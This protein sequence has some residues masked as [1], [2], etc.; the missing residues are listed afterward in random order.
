[1]RIPADLHETIGKKE[2]RY[3]LKT[4]SIGEAKTRARYVAGQV[5]ALFRRLKLRGNDMGELGRKQISQ[6]IREFVYNALE[7]E[8]AY[9]IDRKRPMNDDELEQ[10]IES[11]GYILSDL[12][13]ELATGRHK[14]ARRDVDKI[15]E[16]KGLRIDKDSFSYNKLC[17]EVLKAQVQIIE[18][19]IR[20]RR[21]R[22]PAI[23]FDQREWDDYKPPEAVSLKEVIKAFWDENIQAD[24]WAD[25]TKTEY[26]TCLKTMIRILGDVPIDSITHQTMREFKE[27]LMKLPAYVSN[28]P[29]YDGKSIREILEM[30]ADQKLSISS[31]NKYLGIAKALF[32]F[33]VRNNYITSNP[34]EGLQIS[35]KKRKRG[36]SERRAVFT[37]EDLTLLL[38]SQEYLKDKHKHPHNFWLPLL[39]LFTGARIEELCQ[40][41]VE[42]VKELNG[43][44]VLDI[45]ANAQ[46][47]RLKTPDSKRM[48]PLH[49]FLVE[50]LRFIKFV[51]HQGSQGHERI[52]PELRRINYRYS[53][54]PSKWFGSYRKRCGISD[55]D[56][57]FHSFRHGFINYLK[58]EEVNL[59]I[60]K[61]LVGH[62]D[63]DIT[64]GVYGKSFP[65][66]KLYHEAISKM[67]F[68]VDLSHLKASR[69]CRRE[70]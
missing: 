59:G 69:F 10:D 15:I 22:Y 12:R 36:A 49:P 19:V 7:E 60:I 17:R 32:N 18:E 25:R 55:S 24:N 46:D 48:I 9:L 20:R 45:N 34:A 64:S 8:E 54:A 1:M 50:D 51:Q 65:P 62:S 43:V 57:T 61:Q 47:K 39:G 38:R 56:K 3:S 16:E 63:S 68:G 70:C 14:K 11:L 6:I 37:P 5:Q 23:Q 41:Y 4:G 26:D 30:E 35:K 27:T 66:E 44:W 58:Q 21:G 29:R 67:D 31:V 28:S 53:H 52:F 13:E 40:L 33:A 42:D 2:L